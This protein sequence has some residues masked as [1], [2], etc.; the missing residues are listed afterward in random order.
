[1]GVLGFGGGVHVWTGG[2][3]YDGISIAMGI[4]VG[5]TKMMTRQRTDLKAMEPT[6]RTSTKTST[7]AI[8]LT[9]V[10]I[11]AIIKCSTAM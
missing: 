11:L 10:T 9:R 4:I 8:T 3:E 5:M 2:V 6:T 1:M 7:S